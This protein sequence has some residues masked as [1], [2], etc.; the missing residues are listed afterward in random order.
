MKKLKNFII[1]IVGFAVVCAVAIFGAVLYVE[2]TPTDGPIDMLGE[3]SAEETKYPVLKE[4]TL[5]A[6]L[7]PGYIDELEEY[8]IPALEKADSKYLWLDSNWQ[9][10]GVSEEGFNELLAEVQKDVSPNDAMPY[11]VN[12]YDSMAANVTHNFTKGY[13]DITYKFQTCFFKFGG[14]Q[15]LIVAFGDVFPIEECLSD[16]EHNENPLKLKGL[17]LDMKNIEVEKILCGPSYAEMNLI[18]IQVG[19]DV[20]CKKRSEEF[21]DLEWIPE[22]GTTDHIKF[23]YL[24][25][26]DRVFGGRLHPHDIVAINETKGK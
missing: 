15:K 18:I 5:F 4:T 20:K 16:A 11:F 3:E 12:Q 22:K 24:C 6:E 1:F 9:L 7:E 14:Y 13:N 8:V 19:A 25:Y 21:A 26:T 10:L 2:L 17:D 23:V